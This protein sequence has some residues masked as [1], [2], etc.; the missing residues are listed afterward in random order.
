MKDVE[1]RNHI[2]GSLFPLAC[3]CQLLRYGASCLDAALLNDA[4]IITEVS[5]D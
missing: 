5:D 1:G 2:S 4:K 3:A